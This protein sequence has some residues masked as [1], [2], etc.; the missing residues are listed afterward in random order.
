MY[1]TFDFTQIY[2]G[3]KEQFLGEKRG[4]CQNHVNYCTTVNHTKKISFQ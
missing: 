1:Q 4:N 2:I 3:E